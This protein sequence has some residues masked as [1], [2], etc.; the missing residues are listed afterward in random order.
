MNEENQSGGGVAPGPG[1]PKYQA[2]AQPMWTFS[3]K[4]FHSMVFDG[5][6][7]DL[8]ISILGAKA[9]PH[10]RDLKTAPQHSPAN[11][12]PAL[13]AGSADVGPD[14]SERGIV[15]LRASLLEL[16]RR[17]LEGD[18]EAFGVVL[19]MSTFAANSVS[20][21][22]RAR[23][24]LAQ[25]Y[26]GVMTS[27]PALI[28]NEGFLL[29][30]VKDFLFSKLGLAKLLDLKHK[31]GMALG[32]PHRQI[33]LLLIVYMRLLKFHNPGGDDLDQVTLDCLALGP[34]SKSTQDDW[35]D[36]AKRIF[37]HNWKYVVAAKIVPEFG[38]HKKEAAFCKELKRA[39]LALA[40]NYLQSAADADPSS[41]QPSS[42]P[43][44]ES[45]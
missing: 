32:N 1:N 3:L 19:L 35:A 45:R 29:D 34:F 11:S 17:S 24:D 42:L 21:L 23:P 25:K 16:E 15:Q 37:L 28:P 31:F 20:R 9:Y 41:S 43:R 18:E 6:F 44:A 33:A 8:I 10:L 40:P 12:D 39:F 30:H 36:C 14:E 13:K 4:Q 7:E 5:H 38:S 2:P 22:S 27:W 26:S